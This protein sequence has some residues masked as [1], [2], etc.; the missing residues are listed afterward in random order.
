MDRYPR[1]VRSA[2]VKCIQCNAP[3]AETTDDT[4]VCVECGKQLFDP[5]TESRSTAGGDD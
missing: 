2:R 5:H 4:Y 3:A 1:G